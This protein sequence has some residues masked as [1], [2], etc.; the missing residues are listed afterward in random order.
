MADAK[1]IRIEIDYGLE[2]LKKCNLEGSDESLNAVRCIRESRMAMGRYLFYAGSENPYPNMYDE[3]NE[4]IE[5]PVDKVDQDL[6]V[7]NEDYSQ[8]KHI[9]F[10]VRGFEMLLDKMIV[11]RMQR[12]PIPTPKHQLLGM[13]SL[14]RAIDLMETGI[15]YLGADLRRI[16]LESPGVYPQT[17]Q[18]A[19]Q[20]DPDH[21]DLPE[22]NTTTDRIMEERSK[23]NNDGEQ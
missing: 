23:E 8:V 9:K 3:R 5:M 10:M 6:V 20:S 21:R 15:C 16:S 11:I 14:N 7:V 13:A 12:S 2:Y 18:A 1:E 19:V 17:K 4:I 22:E